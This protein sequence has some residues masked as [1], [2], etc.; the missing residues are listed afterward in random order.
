MERACEYVTDLWFPANPQLLS[1]LRSTLRTPESEVA[2]DDFVRELQGDYSLFLYTLRNMV[3]MLRNEGIQTAGISSPA[4]IIYQ[5]GLERLKQIIG[6]EELSISRHFFDGMSETQLGR[7]QEA[8][9]SA[10]TVQALAQD[11]GIDECLGF[12]AALVRQL[13]HTLIS[14]NYPGVY[15]DALT[16]V[17]ADGINLDHF[18]MQKLGFS[19]SMLALRLVQQWEFPQEYLVAFE[20]EFDLAELEAEEISLEVEATGQAL[21]ELCRVGEALARANQPDRY[22]SA[23]TDWE[24]AEREITSRLGTNG[25]D[26]VR[27]AI[28]EN[29]QSYSVAVPHFFRGGL[30]LDPE[31]IRKQDQADD[32]TQNPYLQRCLP[33]VQ[34][35]LFELYEGM[36]LGHSMQGL[37]RKLTQHIVPLCGFTGALVFTV[38]PTTATLVPQLKVGKTV[39]RK[40]EPVPC[41]AGNQEDLVALAYQSEQPICRAGLKSTQEEYFAGATIFGFSQRVGVIYAEM[42]SS[43]FRKAEQQHVVHLRAIS[44]AM[45]DCLNL[46]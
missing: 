33:E 40:N 34:S 2:V 43:R 11:A 4:E 7:M 32:A 15:Q 17:K 27:T 26:V 3:T 29:C 23:R 1:R 18:I 12:S 21:R 13:G 10:S 19:P 24:F 22:P 28:E 39:L 46:R 6:S 25:M 42:P 44:V 20:R 30:I 45:N 35:H 31:S 5:G 36:R 8:M 41:E 14:W 37:L 38:D 16:A 9:V